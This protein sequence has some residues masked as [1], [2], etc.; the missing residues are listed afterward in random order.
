MAARAASTAKKHRVVGKPFAKGQS[1]NPKGRPAGSRNKIAEDFVSAMAK[2]FEKHGE[3]A[4]RVVRA[5][6][7]EVYLK[8]VADLV[9]KDLHVEHSGSEAFMVLW[10][11]MAG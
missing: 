11:R 9:P 2:D 5:R 10:Q 3:A 4:I 6:K 8:I 1:G 7:P